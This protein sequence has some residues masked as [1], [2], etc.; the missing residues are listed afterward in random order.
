MRSPPGEDGVDG[1]DV[2]HRGQAHLVPGETKVGPVD[3]D[4]GVQ[5]D[6]AV[7]PD[8]RRSIEGEGAGTVAD[9]QGAVHRDTPSR[10]PDFVQCEDDAPV[11]V[12]VEEVSRPQVRVALLVLGVDR[13][14]GHRDDAA[15][16][17]VREDGTGPTDLPEDAVHGDQPHDPA[18]QSDTGPAWIQDPLPGEC[19]VAPQSLQLRCADLRVHHAPATCPTAAFSRLNALIKAMWRIRDAS[20]GSPK[21]LAASAKISSGTGSARSLSRV[22]ASARAKA[23]RSAS[24]KKGV[25]RQAATA[26]IRSSLSPAS[27]RSPACI[28]TQ[29]LQPLIWLA[30]RWTN[31]V[32]TG[33]RSL[34]PAA[35]ASACS[36]SS[37]PGTLSAGLAIRACMDPSLSHRTDLRCH[38]YDTPPRRNVTDGRSRLVGGGLREEPEAP[39]GGGLPHARLARRGRRRRP[40]GLVAPQRG[41]RQRCRQPRR[42]ADHDPGPGVPERAALARH[43][44]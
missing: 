39:A 30:R 2:V 11:V 13:C 23:A 43:P 4:L 5:P 7:T 14:C 44:A 6:L 26:Q 19:P 37:A 27:L 40:G 15:D 36:A 21:C 12:A 16:L 32:V 38:L 42:L 22:T 33:G 24:V 28:W 20:A 8:G 41:R 35:V 18:L 29:T 17:A 25:S 31:S 3:V 34:P 9:G 1:Q 10:G